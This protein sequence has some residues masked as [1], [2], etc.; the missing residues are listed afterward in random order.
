VGELTHLAQLARLV[1]QAQNGKAPVQRLAD[2]VSAY[3]VPAVI[4]LAVLTFGGWLVAGQPVTAALSAAI[5]VLV[6]ACPCALGLATPTALLAGTGRGAQLG[7][8]I[9]GPQV[10]ENTRRVDT[11]VLDKTGTVTAGAMTVVGVYPRPGV[12]ESELLHYAGAV[13]NASEHPI[14][15]VIAAAAADRSAFVTDFVALPG[16]GAEGTVD[17]R[18]V[19]VGRAALLASHAIPVEESTVD[20]TTVHVA[21][22]GQ[23]R[24]AIEVRD[25]VKPTSAEAVSRL[26]ALGLRPVLL[27]GDTRA[28]AERAARAVGIDTVVAEVLP[29][30]KVEV[31]RDLQRQGAVVAMVGDG[32]NDAAALA[33]ADLGIAM[34]SG[35]DVAI[36]ASDLTV[37][38]RVNGSVD[39]RAAADAVALSRITLRTIKANLAWAFGYNAAMIPIA[40]AGLISPMLAA[41]AMA[42]SSVSVVGNSL[43]LFHFGPK[44]ASSQAHSTA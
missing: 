44:R 29:A 14:A 10:L 6:V 43:R 12:T 20:G 30:A 1:A 15:R 40:A 36:E 28:S 42:L 7:L 34:G 17:G 22:D 19:V 23:W 5:A 8:L 21:W 18:R 41:A 13:E 24:G 26:R 2:R 32:V 35:S 38:R 11:V 25:E 16:L 31:V 37:I 9:R 39:L 33:Q 27:T 4:G 3:F